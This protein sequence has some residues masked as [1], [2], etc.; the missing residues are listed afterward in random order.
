MLN[1]K[2]NKYFLLFTGEQGATR[3]A[4]TKAQI[5]AFQVAFPSLKEQIE[6]VI[7]IDKVS[8]ETKRLEDLYQQKLTDL[9]ELK[10]SI[11]QKAFN[12]ELNTTKICV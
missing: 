4:I 9:V 3:Q 5:E 1:S 2:S 12:G 10:K 7:K 8:T 11:L 6:I